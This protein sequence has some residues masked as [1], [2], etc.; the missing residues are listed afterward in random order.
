MNHQNPLNGRVI[1]II[2]LILGF[3]I[4][5]AINQGWLNKLSSGEV[6]EKVEQWFEEP[7]NEFETEIRMEEETIRIEETIDLEKLIESQFD[8]PEA[9]R[10]RPIAF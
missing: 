4:Y 8:K 7:G 5:L 6:F 2:L 10:L 3:F 9:P 1:A